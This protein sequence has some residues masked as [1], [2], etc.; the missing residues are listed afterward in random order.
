MKSA[1]ECQ[2]LS[3]F[4]QKITSYMNSQ[5][6]KFAEENGYTL[7]EALQRGNSLYEGET[8]NLKLN[9]FNFKRKLPNN[10]E[11]LKSDQSTKKAKLSDV[12][13]VDESSFSKFNIEFSYVDIEGNSVCSREE[14]HKKDSEYR[15]K[16]IYNDLT[17]IE[18]GYRLDWAATIPAPHVYAYIDENLAPAISSSHSRETK[19]AT[20]LTRPKLELTSPASSSAESAV[21]KVIKLN[22]KSMQEPT[23]TLTSKAIVL[24]RKSAPTYEIKGGCY[25]IVLL[26][27]SRENFGM[28]HL[29]Q[30]LLPTLKSRNINC[31]V[32]TLTV[33]DF[34][35]LVKGVSSDG[36]VHEAILD[37]I[38]ERKKA[39]DLSQSLLSGRLE[40]QKSRMLT[41]G[42]RNRFLLFEKCPKYK[43]LKIGTATLF[44]SLINSQ[45]LDGFRVMT[46]D[47]AQH[48]IEILIEIHKNLCKNSHRDLLIFKKTPEAEDYNRQTNNWTALDEVEYSKVSAKNSHTQVYELFA[49]HLLQITGVSGPAVET[50]LNFYTTPKSLIEAFTNNFKTENQCDLTCQL[51]LAKKS[52]PKNLVN[53]IDHVYTTTI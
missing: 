2:S 23:I 15:I 40:E 36:Q 53:L 8:T 44:Q 1:D 14:A 4:G 17:S 48:T 12:K 47:G 51:K 42:F 18:E 26:L 52:I 31:Q 50:I 49:K 35:W 10:S 22:P 20:E 27:D 7:E 6:R 24:N 28:G 46:S 37:C 38:I 45:L 25:E 11:R 3:G 33:G 30:I 5:L 21:S 13:P 16:C 19:N 41:T 34:A 29:K 9:K 39:D 43:N 32:R